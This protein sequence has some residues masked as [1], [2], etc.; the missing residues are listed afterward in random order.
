MGEKIGRV[1]SRKL[2]FEMYA[3]FWEIRCQGRCITSISPTAEIDCSTRASTATT[4][5]IQRFY[6]AAARFHC[7]KVAD[8]QWRQGITGDLLW[9]WGLLYTPLA[10]TLLVFPSH[11]IHAPWR[12][13][14]LLFVC[15]FFFPISWIVV[16]LFTLQTKS[17][18]LHGTSHG[19]TASNFKDR[20]VKATVF[21]RPHLVL[22][23]SAV[24]HN[25]KHWPLS[26]LVY[27]LESNIIIYW[28][29]CFK[30][31]SIMTC[32]VEL[33]RFI[34]F[35]DGGVI[36]YK[37]QISKYRNNQSALLNLEKKKLWHIWLISIGHRT[38]IIN[39]ELSAR[40]WQEGK[41]KWL[42]RNIKLQRQMMKVR[43]TIS[44]GERRFSVERTTSLTFV[45]ES[46]LQELLL[47]H[48]QSISR[49][50]NK[51]INPSMWTY[52]M[53]KINTKKPP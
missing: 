20:K 10:W 19:S 11:C 43:T 42:E 41:K 36:I 6:P 31:E 14:T 51:I 49:K 17:C 46:F 37:M 16:V 8:T 5:Q 28:L 52:F 45:R 48:N 7:N 47:F 30:R 23:A 2:A 1:L 50:I 44:Q 40:L 13:D 18:C 4:P 35:W 24:I 27:F 39:S 12:M 22:L 33:K 25:H 34:L 29:K 3:I 38:C 26:R 32:E 21:V 15:F 9:N 53:E